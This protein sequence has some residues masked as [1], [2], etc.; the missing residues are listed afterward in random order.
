M[1]DGVLTIQQWAQQ[2]TEASHKLGVNAENA[3]IKLIKE[4]VGER[5]S[6]GLIQRHF[7]ESKYRSTP[8]APLKKSTL[9]RRKRY[10]KKHPA[11]MRVPGAGSNRPLLETGLMFDSLAY[12]KRKVPGGTK[13][14]IYFDPRRYHGDARHSYIYA[15]IHN[16]GAS[17]KDRNGITHGIP[18]RQFIGADHAG[19]PEFD[20]TI[21]TLN[22]YIFG[23]YGTSLL[24][25]G[26]VSNV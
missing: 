5:G 11:I 17:F 4:L 23:T 13:I 16:Q 21:N 12:L 8:W 15:S 18:Q 2:M 19:Q 7:I 14:R 26:W 24:P 20:A 22:R 1:A 10:L 25:G 6:A 3:R 9:E